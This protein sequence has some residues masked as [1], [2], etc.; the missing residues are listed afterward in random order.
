MTGETP[1][2]LR[3]W[4]WGRIILILSLSLNLL[5][6]GLVAGTLLGGGPER[7]PDRRPEVADLGFGPY[8]AALEGDDRKMLVQAARREGNGLRE[9]RAQVRGQFEALL[10]LLRAETLDVAALDR[11]LSEQQAA[12]SDWQGIG[13]RLLI[14]HLSQMDEAERAA[15]AD[16][17]DRLLR[18][19]PPPGTNGERPGP[20]D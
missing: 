3:G 1:K 14:E 9:H 16:R 5:V 4:P 18:R 6:V 2:T 20:R 19:R 7:A 10:A 11:L 12:L 8:V 15:Y 13:Q 17:L